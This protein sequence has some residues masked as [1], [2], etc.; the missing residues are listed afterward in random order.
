MK[1]SRLNG[2]D[3]YVIRIGQQRRVD[4]KQSSNCPRPKEANPCL[5]TNN[6]DSTNLEKKLSTGSLHDELKFP[7]P[8]VSYAAQKK[9][10]AYLDCSMIRASRPCYRCVE[11]MHSVGIKRVFW[12]NDEGHWEGR[13]VHELYDAFENLTMDGTKDG[14][15]GSGAFVTKHEVL[16]LRRTM[17]NLS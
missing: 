12:T 17:G 9:Q 1:S 13:K 10:S 14:I 8:R 11:Y 4:Q 3:L 7:E 2:A 16:M 5:P 15:A 6:Q